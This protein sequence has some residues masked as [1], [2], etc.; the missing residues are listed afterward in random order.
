M[1]QFQNNTFRRRKP[2]R[3]SNNIRQKNSQLCGKSPKWEWRT[4]DGGATRGNQ[5]TCAS[6]KCICLYRS[7]NKC[8]A[9][10]M[11]EVTQSIPYCK[12]ITVDCCN[13]H[14]MQK[15]FWRGSL[16]LGADIETPKVL[17]GLEEGYP[18]PQP[19]RGSGEHHE[20]P[21]PSPGR[22]SRHKRLFSIF[23]CHRTLLVKRKCNTAT[24]E[25]YWNSVENFW[26]E[27]FQGVDPVNP[28]LKYGPGCN[29]VL[30]GLIQVNASRGLQAVKL[31]TAL[32]FI[33]KKTSK[34]SLLLEHQTRRLFV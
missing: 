20:L 22:I 21:Q 25:I 33:R 2:A 31:L 11:A 27:H 18:P 34:I 3:S 19:C 17:G 9:I 14:H 28:P 12:L 1:Q 15:K 4:N 6:S 32:S 16:K 24:E 30:I 26:G 23:E 5:Y 29:T 7:D 13:Q 10:A 8:L